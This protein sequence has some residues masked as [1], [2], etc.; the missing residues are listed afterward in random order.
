MDGT[1]IE[2]DVSELNAPAAFVVALIAVRTQQYMRD[3][4]LQI[5]SNTK[6]MWLHEKL[7]ACGYRTHISTNDDSVLTVTARTR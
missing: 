3:I 1:S 2:I 5:G 4:A 7:R 6:R